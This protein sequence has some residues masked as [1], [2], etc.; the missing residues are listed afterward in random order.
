MSQIDPPMTPKLKPA[1]FWLAAQLPPIGA[2]LAR[3]GGPEKVWASVQ[4]HPLAALAIA[5][6]WQVLLFT[7]AFAKQV[8]A[9]LEPEAINSVVGT[10]QTSTR[11]LFSRFR[12]RYLQ[13]VIYE[14]N[15]FNT[16]GLRTQGA[17]RIRLADVFVQLKLAPNAASNA[18]LDPVAAKELDDSRLIFDFLRQIARAPGFA[19]AIIGAPG[20]GKTTLLQYL[21]LLFARNTQSKHRL[22]PHFPILF[23]YRDYATKAPPMLPALFEAE[24]ARNNISC[25][26][27]WLER[28]LVKGDVIILLDGLD[29]VADTEQRKQLSRWTDVQIRTYPQ[30]SFVLTARPLGYRAAPLERAHVLEILPFTWVQVS[31]FIHDWY[32]ANETMRAGGTEDETA[33]LEARR[34]GTDLLDRLR[35]APQL[36]DLTRN[37]LLLTMIATVHSTRGALPGKRVELYA[38]I[39][40]VELGRWHEA[41]GL[42]SSLTPAQYR[43]VLE[44]LA[45]RMMDAK[46]RILTLKQAAT[47]IRGPLEKVGLQKSEAEDFLMEVQARSGLFVEHEPDQWG[48]AHLTFQEYLAASWWRGLQD[49]DELQHLTTIVSDSWW[50]ELLRLY[51][52]MADAS[53]VVRACLKENSI[54]AMSL[55]LELLV[56]AREVD[57]QLRA[58]TEKRLR[59]DLESLDSERFR[60]A[61]EVSLARRLR[62]LQSL[63]DQRAIDPEYITHGEYRHFLA[64]ARGRDRFLR[65]PQIWRDGRFAAGHGHL[66]VVGVWHS[67]AIEFCRWLTTRAGDNVSYRLPTGKEAETVGHND[68][69]DISCWCDRGKKGLRLAGMSRTAE[70]SFRARLQA[71]SPV[72]VEDDIMIPYELDDIV[73]RGA[74]FAGSR[75]RVPILDRVLRDLVLASVGLDLRT[76]AAAS[77]DRPI[78]LAYGYATSRPFD[79]QQ[80]ARVARAIALALSKDLIDPEEAMDMS[81]WSGVATRCQ[82]SLHI[83]ERAAITSGSDELSVLRR[84]RLTLLLDLALLF[85]AKEPTAIRQQWRSFLANLTQFAWMAGSKD[86]KFMSQQVGVIV[87]RV[88]WLML[89]LRGREAGSLPAW[90]GIRIVREL[91]QDD[92][93]GSKGFI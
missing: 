64:D 76:V 10:L 75:K 19:L 78:E 44:P 81:D 1:L 79:T 61:A 26:T 33:R 18:R 12:R 92:S 42:S 71:L 24:C 67:D 59:E 63:D 74:E 90:E 38:E 84:H 91:R 13:K 51:S 16:R 93:R 6:G 62:H 34:Q 31:Q 66:P 56:E 58:A 32:R 21:A 43:T 68:A 54:E 28:R 23:Q 47:I 70:L 2:A 72:P 37:P 17:F 77:I 87:R 5:I 73:E 36:S 25:P 89:I 49:R 15:I 30:S 22:R 35:R 69:F 88:H 39:C 8:W 65:D 3:A 9:R 4:S 48:F 40:D 14:N 45:A 46:T 55:A 60:L 86:G 29:E 20:S 11:T 85:L 52:A 83:L 7:A 41:K 57:A 82:A 50:H 27:G 53:D 80:S